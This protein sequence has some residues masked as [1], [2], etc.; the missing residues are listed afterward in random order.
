MGLNDVP[1]TIR[2]ATPSDAGSIELL[3]HEFVT[4]LRSIGDDTVYR[5]GATRYLADGFGADPAFR[6]LVAEDDTGLNG[7]VLFCKTYE[8]DYVRACYIVDL[9]VRQDSRGRGLGRLLMN[10]VREL[11][12]HEGLSRLSWSVHKNNASAIR[13]YESLGARCVSDTNVMFLDLT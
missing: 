10:A 5:F 9:Y 8:G 13:F 12:R 4:Y 3:F 2:A 7:Y 1:M 11:A 6:G